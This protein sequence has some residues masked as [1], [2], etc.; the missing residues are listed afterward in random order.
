M[1]IEERLELLAKQRAA[2]GY[3]ELLPMRDSS[4]TVFIAPFLE[5]EFFFICRAE[6]VK[7]RDANRM[8]LIFKFLGKADNIGPDE[9]SIE[10]IR[11]GVPTLANLSDKVLRQYLLKLNELHFIYKTHSSY[12]PWSPDPSSESEPQDV[13]WKRRALLAERKLNTICV[14][15]A[16]AIHQQE[17]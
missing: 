4:R 11:N 17:C 12:K 9:K 13:D 15:V 3:S 5:R 6:N 2:Y 7:R 1:K 16:N 10:M 8:W 14:A